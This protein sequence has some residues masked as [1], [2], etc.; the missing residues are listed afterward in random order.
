MIGTGIAIVGLSG[1]VVPVMFSA[2]MDRTGIRS[3][4]FMPMCGVIWVWL[5]WMHWTEER[6]NE[7]RASAPTNSISPAEQ[8]PRSGQ[9]RQTP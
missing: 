6:R 9:E 7:R 2:L 8:A 3:S 5:I 1:F 4:A